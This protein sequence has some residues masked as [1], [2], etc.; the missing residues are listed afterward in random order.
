M[1]KLTIIRTNIREL[2]K[3]SVSWTRVH[4]SEI[5]TFTIKSTTP[6]TNYSQYHTQMT[7]GQ[8]SITFYM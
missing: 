2:F 8:N 7:L 1:H 6:K 4:I 3:P 5:K